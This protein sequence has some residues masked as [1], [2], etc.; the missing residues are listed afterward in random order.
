MIK[1][2]FKVFFVFFAIFVFFVIVFPFENGDD[3]FSRDKRQLYDVDSFEPQEDVS[4]LFEKELL[5]ILNPRQSPYFKV[6][7]ED[8]SEYNSLFITNEV[9]LESLKGIEFLVNLETLVIEDQKNLFFLTGVENLKNLKVVRVNNTPIKSFEYNL[10]KLEVLNLKN[11]LVSFPENQ[12]F[13]LFIKENFPNLQE[14]NIKN[15][16]NFLTWEIWFFFEIENKSKITFE[17]DYK[18]IN[19][20]S[21][22]PEDIWDSEGKE[23]FG[24]IKI[25]FPTFDEKKGSVLLS[26]EVEDFWF[27]ITNYLLNAPQLNELSE[28]SVRGFIVNLINH[29][30]FKTSNE[31]SEVNIIKAFEGETVR[32]E[33]IT[34]LFSIALIHNGIHSY[35]VIEENTFIVYY[36]IETDE[37]SID[38]REFEGRM[39]K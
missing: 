36:F 22:S 38:M 30:D 25:N 33:T 9:D 23:N 2:A 26:F 13:I 34:E 7:P 15:T 20:L 5:D 35:T 11:T 8:L 14:F 39:R 28:E 12:D 37:Y 6:T 21:V 17:I 27:R 16:P 32:L 10:E 1:I 24:N 29:F 31:T 18:Q 4:E 3:E 19:W